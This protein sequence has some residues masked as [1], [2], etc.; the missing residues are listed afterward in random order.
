M[1]QPGF[2]Q[3]HAAARQRLLGWVA[4][5]KEQEQFISLVRV[6]QDRDLVRLAFRGWL[7]NIEDIQQLIRDQEARA[8]VLYAQI[9][10]LRAKEQ[11]K[12]WLAIALG[13]RS[14]KVC[15]RLSDQPH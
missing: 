1:S 5:R 6:C 8:A 10:Q 12:H 11:L 9:R 14:R 2:P 15:Q 13:D 3:E 4:R 7:V